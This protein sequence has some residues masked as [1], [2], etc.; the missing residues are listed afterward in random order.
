MS[1]RVTVLIPVRNRERYVGAAI[2][3]ALA[4]T[5]R[6]LEVLV[7]DDASSDG[8]RDV[9]RSFADPRVRLVENETHLGIPGTRNRGV[10]LARG[11]YLAFL[12]SD[13]QALPERLER[14][15]RFLEGHPDYGAVG[16]WIEWMDEEG[17]PLGRVKRKATDSDRIRAERLF[18]SCL[19]N[20]AATARTELLRKLRHRE[21]FTFGSDY[22]VWARMA[23]DHAMATLPE[24]LVRRR[25]HGGRTTRG[26]EQR[27]KEIRLGIFADQLDTFGVAYGAEDLERHYLLRRMHKLGFRPDAAYVDWA[28]RWLLALQAANAAR[29]LYPEP[30]FAE[31]LCGFWLKTCWFAERR[32]SAFRRALR[33]P[34]SRH[35]VPELR[36]GLVEG[37]RRRFPASAWSARR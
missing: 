20:S 36:R 23:A 37:L 3:S 26:Q 16:S 9:V 17:R 10:D 28:E 7:V 29:G 4:Q 2:E 34:L 5:L 35:A 11:E 12:D 31:V 6:D 14:Q 22:D 32:P 15:V 25:T 24:V 8:T 19:E 27:I 21:R 30:A 33:S 18:R 1:I 13:D